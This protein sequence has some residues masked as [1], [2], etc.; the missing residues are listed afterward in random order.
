MRN[1]R[2]MRIGMYTV[3]LVI[4]LI[5]YLS[6]RY[7]QTPTLLYIFGNTYKVNIGPINLIYI[8]PAI[9]FLIGFI[10][11]F[12]KV[13]MEKFR[14]LKI[15]MGLLLLSLCMMFGLNHGFFYIGSGEKLFSIHISGPNWYMFIPTMLVLLYLICEIL[16]KIYSDNS[17]VKI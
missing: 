10:F 12:L 2:K 5:Y 3:G 8:F 1:S 16:R 15:S 7:Y 6:Y 17:K 9:P 14:N 4:F 13:S 11:E